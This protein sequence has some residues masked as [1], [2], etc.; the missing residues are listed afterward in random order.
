VKKDFEIR[1]APRLRL[2]EAETAEYICMSRPFLRL[3]RMKGTGPAYLR[4]G[5]AIRYDVRDLDAW[6]VEHRVACG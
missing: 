5:R 3:A 4:I 6:L 1:K 2:N